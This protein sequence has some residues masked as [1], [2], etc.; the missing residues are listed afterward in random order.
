MLGFVALVPWL[1]LLDT[2]RGWLRALLQG[3]AMA[4]AF[5]LA[6]FAWFGTAIGSYSQAG[7]GVGLAVLLLAAPLFQP[8]FIA[9]ALVRHAASRGHGRL[10]AALAAASAWVATEWLFPKTLGDTLGYGLYPST[11]LRQAADVGGTAGLTFLLLL[12][13][14]GVAAALARRAQGVRAVAKPLVLTALL[15]A[16]LAAYGY[17]VLFTDVFKPAPAETAEARSTTADKPLR[18]GLVQSNIIGYDQ[19]R[20]EKGAEAVLHDILDTH[21][22]MT[23]AAV[24]KQKADAVLWSETVYPLT[25]GHPKTEAAREFDSA[26][27]EVVNAAKVPFIFGTYDVDAEGEY[28]AAAFV[29][30]GR[31]LLGFYRKTRLFPFTE[32]VPAW[33]DNATV[34]GW[35]PWLGTW[36]PGNGARVFPLYV[37]DGREIPV[38]PLICLDDVDTSLAIEGARQGARAI[39]TMSNDSW[40]TD[41][42][43]G[44][45]MHRAAAAFRSIE[46]RLPQFR[47]TNNGYS[48]IFDAQ[49]RVLADSRM[50]ERTL[51]VGDV[52]VGAPHVTLMVAWG[53]WVGAVA[54]VFLVLLLVVAALRRWGPDPRLSEADADARALP[55]P[56]VMLPPAARF[57]AA[58]LRV[59]ARG[60]LLWMVGLFVMG[61]LT[62]NT[63]GQIRLFS[64]FF[65]LPE[66]AAWLV[67]RA[68]SARAML[69]SGTLV[70]LRG[71]QRLEVALSDIAAVR[72]W[73]LPLPAQ[74]AALSLR[75]G[76]AINLA[77][78]DPVAL[79]RVL[80]AAGA[81]SAVGEPQAFTRADRLAQVRA[82]LRPSRLDHPALKYGLLSLVL[83]VPAYRIH[84]II[85][86]G[87]AFGE[88]DAYG[89]WAYVGGFGLWWASWLFGVLLTAAAARA[90]TELGT[91]LAVLVW[92]ARA[93]DARVWLERLGLAV[94]YLGMPGWF[95]Y[96]VFGA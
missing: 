19:L 27:I 71:K 68:F 83:A 15:P 70:L 82:A 40:F 41:A 17:A 86:F 42:P 34:R 84:Q 62:S 52:P 79:A 21:F 20:K 72:P 32:S 66:V 91:L 26:I 31:G 73:R 1:L 23:Y 67:L 57:V 95:A 37:P 63:F 3:W 53:D 48:A 58:A 14:E 38:L 10:L 77:H 65:L 85:N 8:Q 69:E 51:L 61:Q 22:A 29:T 74:G 9:F 28:N 56:V 80:R 4:L 13:N 18:M 5:T 25:F 55:A 54:S 7:A 39:V 49:G 78:A 43:L 64:V 44:A 45:E 75:E 87:S 89:F 94:L 46:T 6:A 35:L 93:L 30:P 2:Q 50:G 36:R 47:V 16:L 96:R 60:S 11:L 59:L 88:Y 81:A 33:L 24:E 76:R 90:V 92:P 12:A